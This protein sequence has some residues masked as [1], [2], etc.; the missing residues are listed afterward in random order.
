MLLLALFRPVYRAALPV[1]TVWLFTFSSAVPGEAQPAPHRGTIPQTPP[2]DSVRRGGAFPTHPA[3]VAQ[4]QRLFENQCSPCHNFRQAGIG[5]ALGRVTAEASPAW[6]RA[7]IRNAPAQLARHDARATRLFAEYKQAM[8]AFPTLRDTD[9]DALL[10]YLYANRQ[11]A[12]AGTDEDAGMVLKDPIPTKIPKADL[13]LT[14]AEVLTAP[15][16][17]QTAPLARINKMAVLP[18][19]ASPDR[20]FLQELRGVLYELVGNDLRVAMDIRPLRPQFIHEPGHGTG[21]GSFAFHPEFYRNGLLYT[22]HAEKAGSAP[23]DFAYADSIRVSLQ[24]VLT[25]WKVDDPR[26]ATFT[27][28]GREL[29]RVNLVTPI[30]G[31]QEITFNPLARPGSPDYGLL[32]LGIGDGGATE[33]GY[34]FLC[35]DNRHVWGS[36]L[37]I[38][39][40]GRDSRN[41]H[42]GIPAT[43]PFANDPAAV[44]EIYCR[45]FRNPNRLTWAPDGTMLLTDIGQTNAEELNVG[46]A[47][48]DYGWPEREGT[49]RINPR[50]QMKNVY[51][52]PATDAPATYVYPA[53]EY[54]HDEGNAISGGFVYTGSAA[55]RLKGKYV[56]G[57]VVNGRVFFVESRALRPGGL[58]PIQE[59]S[60]R[61]GDKPTTFLEMTG[62]KKADFRIGIGPNG[63]LYFFT[64]T[65]GKLYK[66]TGCEP[67]R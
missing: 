58:A 14:L 10:A 44:R 30:H 37:R 28:T 46:L 49:F 52:R 13:R 56:F 35:H 53:A 12:T 3:L 63:E 19:G 54:D 48:A 50:A 22:S 33:Q 20:V 60:L 40:R 55:P 11:Q 51:P 62:A 24:W 15:P 57:D 43:N 66:V 29:L 36:V 21:F 25:E 31:M 9:L 47:G 23:A 64:K 41:G 26:A 34:G 18:G 8:P 39:P 6:L 32:Y 65:D 61:V 5:P 38:D 4:G 67:V 27:G 42:Y 1:L 16:T 59:L 7:F 17:A 2:A 45:G